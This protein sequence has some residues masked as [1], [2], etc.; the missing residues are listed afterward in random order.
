MSKKTASNKGAEN[1][2]AGITFVTQWAAKS[3]CDSIGIELGKRTSF[4]PAF[5]CS[6]GNKPLDILGAKGKTVCTTLIELFMNDMTLAD[7][8]TRPLY[9]FL[10]GLPSRLYTEDYCNRLFRGYKTNNDVQCV[11]L[12]NTIGSYVKYLPDNYNIT[13]QKKKDAIFVLIEGLTALI[14]TECGTTLTPI[15]DYDQYKRFLGDL[16]AKG[17]IV[18]NSEIPENNIIFTLL[19]NISEKLLP[20][21]PGTKKTTKKSTT[22]SNPPI[23]TSDEAS[24]DAAELLKSM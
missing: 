7:Y 9:M 4:D 23:A 17:I 18:R 14:W 24:T 16:V 19:N 11:S 6:A 20:A 3:L 15:K 10:E 2:V 22:A 12:T 1:I 21:A 13:D 8:N 5:E